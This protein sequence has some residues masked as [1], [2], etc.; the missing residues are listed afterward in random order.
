MTNVRVMI[1]FFVY[2][3]FEWKVYLSNIKYYIFT[4][5]FMLLSLSNTSVKNPDIEVFHKICVI[6]TRLCEDK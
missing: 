3:M 2:L 6:K 4:A 5:I 1:Y